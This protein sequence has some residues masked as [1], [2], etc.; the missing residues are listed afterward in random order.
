MNPSAS[1]K[2][3]RRLR[4]QAGRQKGRDG[5]SGKRRRFSDTAVAVDK[6]SMAHHR[7][8]QRMKEAPN[9]AKRIELLAYSILQAMR[10]RDRDS[11]AAAL[12]MLHECTKKKV[13]VRANDGV[14]I[15]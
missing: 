9:R 13:N 10:G 7:L 14:S 11:F 1:V 5:R 3:K 15:A 6:G 2:S 12:E 4:K 8:R